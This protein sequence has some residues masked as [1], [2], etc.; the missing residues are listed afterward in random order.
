MRT[1]LERQKHS[2]S[3]AIFSTEEEEEQ[4]LVQPA[5]CYA[6]PKQQSGTPFLFGGFRTN[7]P[8]WNF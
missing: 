5:R 3:Q 7:V 6:K 2:I 1:L 4:E 8:I